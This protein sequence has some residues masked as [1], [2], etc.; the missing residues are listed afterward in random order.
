MSCDL[1]PRQGRGGEVWEEGGRERK[2]GGREGGRKGVG[3]I[4]E[5]LSLCCHEDSCMAFLSPATVW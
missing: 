3:V 2:V 4:M 5:C 1:L